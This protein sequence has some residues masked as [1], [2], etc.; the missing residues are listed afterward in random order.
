[1]NYNPGISHLSN[2][3]P[4]DNGRYNPCNYPATTASPLRPETIFTSSRSGVLPLEIP[5]IKERVFGI[6]NLIQKD[7]LSLCFYDYDK[8]N[9]VLFKQTNTIRWIL[10]KQTK[11]YSAK[12]I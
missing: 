1:M 12:M 3:G 7:Q 9:P 4:V 6:K 10:D 11:T 2:V 5:N 8:P